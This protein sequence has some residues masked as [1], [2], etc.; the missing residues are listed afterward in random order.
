MSIVYD[1]ELAELFLEE[2]KT[3]YGI[4]DSKTL[5][6]YFICRYLSSELMDYQ[7]I[8]NN[9]ESMF[10][11]LEQQRKIVDFTLNE[12]NLISDSDCIAYKGT[13][14]T[15]YMS[16]INSIINCLIELESICIDIFEKE[17]FYDEIKTIMKKIRSSSNR[18]SSSKKESSNYKYYLTY[19]ALFNL[20]KDFEV[21]NIKESKLYKKFDII[22]SA[23][24][25]K[26]ED[27]CSRY[28]DAESESNNNKKNDSLLISEDILERFIYRNLSLIEDG[29]RPIKR[30]YIIRD[31][32]IDILAKDK[33]DVYTIIEL[34]VENDTDLIFQCVHYST[35]LKL[36]KNVSNVR[37]ITISPEYSYGVLNALKNIKESFNIESYICYIKVKGIKN[38]KID[39]VE[40]MKII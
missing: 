35:E 31:G 40:L 20:N 24:S 21:K 32:R 6:K 7:K 16:G 18:K 5:Y 27:R 13:V 4:D 17:L 30:Q 36:D 29:L 23:F 15:K 38:K 34:K 10:Y 1:L 11:N 9:L 22:Q 28:I 2:L 14:V 19:Y 33:N 12:L 3:I 8:K 25:T 26:L 39:S 37:V